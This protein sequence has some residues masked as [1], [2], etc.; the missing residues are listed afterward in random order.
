MCKVT[1]EMKKK[2][3]KPW[4]TEF[5]SEFITTDDVSKV[6]CYIYDLFQ[7]EHYSKLI[8]GIAFV[9]II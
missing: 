1:K 4:E 7:H 5:Y 8:S 2:Y 3:N 6:E 9:N